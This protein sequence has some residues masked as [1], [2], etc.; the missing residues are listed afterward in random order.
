MAESAPPQPPEAWL[1][2][3]DRVLASLEIASTRQERRRGL[4]GRLGLDGAL[5]IERCRSVHSV[6]MRF[7][8]DVAFIDADGGVIRLVTL[9]RAGLATCMQARSAIEVEAGSFAR[10]GVSEGDVLEVRRGE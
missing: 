6:G 4:R 1:L 9:D 8:I 5:L 2:F 7:A 3:G 10:W